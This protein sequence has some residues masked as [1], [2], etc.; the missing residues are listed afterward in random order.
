MI[1]S[2]IDY[3]GQT[4]AV[5]YSYDSAMWPTNKADVQEWKSGFSDWSGDE[6]ISDWNQLIANFKTV[7]QERLAGMDA[8]ITSGKFTK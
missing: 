3:Y 2:Q 1:V 6:Q 4:L 5:S 7:Y 8:L